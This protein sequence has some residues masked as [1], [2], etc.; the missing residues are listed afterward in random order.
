MPIHIALATFAGFLMPLQALINARTA[1]VVG[2]T[3]WPTVINF[4][5][6]TVMIAAIAV[7]MRVPPPAA[8]QI[9][10]I[11][12]YGW[13]SGLLGLIFVAQAAFTIPKLG[14]A[15]MMSLIVAGQLLGSLLFD[16]LGILQEAQPITWEKLAGV[17]LLM[18]GVFL[19]LRPDR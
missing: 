2:G 10:R 18:A 4:A 13:F 8:E 1:A 14:A 11:P 7:T 9:V 17:G 15:A 12:W 5:G 3:F 16:R 6:G 19:I